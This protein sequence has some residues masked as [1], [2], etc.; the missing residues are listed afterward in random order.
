MP[1][2]W[3]LPR[4][5]SLASTLTVSLRISDVLFLKG[6][7]SHWIRARP[8]DLVQ[9]CSPL[10][11]PYLQKHHC[12]RSW[13]P[14]RGGTVQS[15]TAV[16]LGCLS[17][18]RWE[19]NQSLTYFSL[20]G[21]LSQLHPTPANLPWSCLL[22]RAHPL[23]AAGPFLPSQ[24]LSAPRHTAVSPRLAHPGAPARPVPAASSPGP[25]VLLS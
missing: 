19:S 14:G 16:R 22:L 25:C 23:I 10:Y 12:L 11:R 7:Q 24:L 21:C 4:P 15:I 9:T 2:G 6:H 20:S 5:L 8:H 1:A 13:G 17:W 18:Q 3:F